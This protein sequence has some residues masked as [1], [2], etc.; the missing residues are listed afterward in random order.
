MTADDDDRDLREAFAGLRREEQ[1]QITELHRLLERARVGRVRRSPR[2]LAPVLVSVAALA[3]LGLIVARGFHLSEPATP[4]GTE[5]AM[6]LSAWTAP[7]A[8]LLRTPG[9]ALLSTLPAF[10][11]ATPPKHP[12]APRTQR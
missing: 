4:P 5:S 8:F 1:A 6:S 9:H 10:P 7:T 3:A 2:A 12:V 11:D